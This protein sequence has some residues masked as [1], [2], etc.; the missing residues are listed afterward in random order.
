MQFSTRMRWKNDPSRTLSVA[1]AHQQESIQSAVYPHLIL[2]FVLHGVPRCTHP[3]GPS[4]PPIRRTAQQF[5]C[6][7]IE[8]GFIARRPY[9]HVA[10]LLLMLR[11][12]ARVSVVVP[13]AVAERIRLGR[14][15]QP[16]VLRHAI[17]LFFLLL[18]LLRIFLRGQTGTYRATLTLSID[19]RDRPLKV[20]DFCFR[21]TRCMERNGGCR[22]RPWP[23]KWS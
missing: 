2:T 14:R 21:F 16:F 11:P 4:P 20:A 9:R 13:I 18:L 10:T 12:F 5:D 6:L 19:G 1:K 7:F 3:A 8:D 15:S 22:C 17:R 23:C